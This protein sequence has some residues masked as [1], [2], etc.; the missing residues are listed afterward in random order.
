[1]ATADVGLVTFCPGMLG[2]GVAGKTPNLLAA[3][4]PI[5]AM[6][7]PGAETAMLLREEQVGWTVPPGDATALAEA[8]R[9]LVS[10]GHGVAAA[11]ARARG[12]AAR[13][14]DRAQMVAHYV[15]IARDLQNPRGARQP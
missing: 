1:M 8:M 2:M 5:L 14:F 7:E 6:L 15:D 3:G 11:A 4:K 9:R 12:A 10:D 13:R